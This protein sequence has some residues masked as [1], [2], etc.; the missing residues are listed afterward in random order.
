MVIMKGNN[1]SGN[2]PSRDDWETPKPLFDKLNKQYKFRYD[3]C[4]SRKNS[5]CQFYSNNFLFTF[6][7]NGMAWMNPPFSKAD[8]MFSHF[9]KVIKKGIAIYRCDNLETKVWQDFILNNA[10]WIFIPKGRISY[11]HN[12]RLSKGARFPRALIGIGVDPPKNIGGKVL[13]CEEQK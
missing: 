2:N 11:E 12:K 5:K 3:C 13:F 10:D 1:G 6:K 7:C 4:A 8:F 9:F